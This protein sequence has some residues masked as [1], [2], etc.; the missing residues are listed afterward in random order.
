MNKERTYVMIKPDAVSRGLIGEIISRIER[1]GLKIISMK[2]E[3]MSKEIAS[4]HYKEHKEKPFFK[5]LVDFITSGPSVSLIVEGMNSIKIMRSLNG[6]TNPVDASIGTIRGDYGIDTGRNLV[7]ASD[8]E[9]AS[10]R[11]IDIHFKENILFEYNLANE[12]YVY[13]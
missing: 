10:K 9:E 2:F 1:K 11:E 4:E 3:I 13:E 12:K 6:S 7:H 5:S 8:S